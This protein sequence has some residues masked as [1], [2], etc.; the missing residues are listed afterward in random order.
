MIVNNID[1]FIIVNYIFIDYS[2]G[3]YIECSTAFDNRCNFSTQVAFHLLVCFPDRTR[4]CPFNQ[5]NNLLTKS[6]CRVLTKGW[7]LLGWP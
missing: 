4:D 6:T 7:N 3:R 2:I 1:K 5:V